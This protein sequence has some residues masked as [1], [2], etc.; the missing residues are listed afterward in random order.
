MET[1]ITTGLQ[2]RNLKLKLL[3]VFVPFF[4]SQPSENKHL[5]FYSVDREL[6]FSHSTYL[7]FLY[8]HLT[9]VKL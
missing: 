2:N 3:V 4:L 9:Q 7:S 8:N 6:T 1:N 5:Y